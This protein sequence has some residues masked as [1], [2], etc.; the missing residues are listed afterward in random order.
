MTTYSLWLGAFKDKKSFNAYA[1]RGRRTTPFEADFGIGECMFQWSFFT[2]R[3][4]NNRRVIGGLWYSVAY[5]DAAAAA[6]KKL[7]IRDGAANAIIACED[8]KEDPRW[9]K[10]T[11]K[12]VRYL[13][14]FEFSKRTKIDALTPADGAARK[15]KHDGWI[16]IWLG[17]FR[18]NAEL[19][20][21]LAEK[22]GKDGTHN[23][24]FGRDF[25]IESDEDFVFGE[26][27]N[28]RSPA[29]AD[30]L[31]GWSDA[32]AYL[33]AALKAAKKAG[34]K[35]ANTAIVV[36]DLRYDDEP[37]FDT[38]VTF[39][40]DAKPNAKAPVR[41]LGAFRSKAGKGKGGGGSKKR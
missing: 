19:D 27:S 28:E 36:R 17:S 35:A 23:S 30:L 31:A 5:A 33:E 34:M 20:R 15:V 24:P 40:S 26:R 21:Y 41:F 12:P 39:R 25:A 37:P 4:E 7:G 11:G 1:E 38:G 8:L 2:E 3:P 18:T 29:L 6:A 14:T 16:S 9:S 13:G 22:R 10:T 32:S